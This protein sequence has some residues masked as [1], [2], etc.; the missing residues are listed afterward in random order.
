M[1][2]SPF[3]GP[4]TGGATSCGSRARPASMTE[5]VGAGPCLRAPAGLSIQ[6]PGPPH[7]SSPDAASPFQ[8]VW[9]KV[10]ILIL[11]LILL[12]VALRAWQ[13]RA[14]A[15]SWSSPLWVGIFPIPGDDSAAT[16]KYVAGLTFKDSAD[17]ET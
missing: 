7:A 10:R 9:K 1:S 2:R 11:L 5:P 3:P 14:R 8:P 16:R 15:T 4:L 12:I 17:I 6:A 13:D